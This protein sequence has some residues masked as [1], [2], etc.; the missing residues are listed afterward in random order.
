VSGLGT[1]C[2]LRPSQCSTTD[3]RA[4]PGTG[5]RSNRAPTAQT[6]SAAMAATPR[7]RSRRPGCARSATVGHPNARSVR[8]IALRVASARCRRPRH[9]S[10]KNRRRLRACSPPPSLL[11]S[12]QRPWDFKSPG[13]TAARSSRWPKVAAM[14]AGA[15]CDEL[16]RDEA[17]GDDPVLSSVLAAVVIADSRGGRTLTAPRSHSDAS[18][19]A[20]F[21]PSHRRT[22]DRESPS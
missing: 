20:L 8:Q 13:R 14:S 19:A 5:G 16:Q 15:R 22:L 7:S 4:G 21:R 17:G 1:T 12:N 9:P 3:R 6:S 18:W 2:Q 10:E 11:D